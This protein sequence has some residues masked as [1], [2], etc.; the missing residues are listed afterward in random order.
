VLRRARFYE[1]V[2]NLTNG[3][4]LEGR[5]WSYDVIDPSFRNVRALVTSPAVKDTHEINRDTF[6]ISATAPRARRACGSGAPFR[7]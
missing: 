5:S 4:R 3:E 1:I 2:F 7:F 6:Q